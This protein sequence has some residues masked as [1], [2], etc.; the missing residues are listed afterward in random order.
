MS[1]DVK[2]LTGPLWELSENYAGADGAARLRSVRLVWG[3][4]WNVE[5]FVTAV[6]ER[7]ERFDPFGAPQRSWLRMR[8]F[9]RVVRSPPRRSVPHAAA[10]YALR[11]RARSRRTR[12][13]STRWSAESPGTTLAAASASTSS[14][15]AITASPRSGACSRRSTVSPIRRGSLRRG[16]SASRPCRPCARCDRRA[17]RPRSSRSSSRSTASP[18]AR[19]AGS[20]AQPRRRAA[21]PRR[22][23]HSASSPS[24]SRIGVRE[25]AGDAAGRGAAARASWA[26]IRTL[27]EGDVTVLEHRTRPTGATSSGSAPTT[28]STGCGSVRPCARCSS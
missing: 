19:R 26:P 1:Q 18:C 12:S 11:R 10:G 2:E 25:P 6:A 16:R 7:F 27:F 21:G 5:G 23:R 8:S 9:D 3:K 24:P 4:A 20:H 22:A 14:R 15:R 13:S 17:P 28:G